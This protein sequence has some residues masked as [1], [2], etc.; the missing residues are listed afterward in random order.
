MKHSL[1]ILTVY[2]FILD[3]YISIVYSMLSLKF[4]L[5]ISTVYALL[6]TLH[7]HPIHLTVYFNHRQLPN[8]LKHFPL[9]NC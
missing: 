5:S 9:L 8:Y 1:S 2:P 4:K 7:I 3:N 6:L